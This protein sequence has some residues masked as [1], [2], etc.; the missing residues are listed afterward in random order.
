MC[1][2]PAGNFQNEEDTAVYKKWPPEVES[3]DG[4]WISTKL[5]MWWPRGNPEGLAQ[6]AERSNLYN[7]WE[8]HQLCLHHGYRVKKYIVNTRSATY[9]KTKRGVMDQPDVVRQTRG[10]AC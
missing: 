10:N 5:Y 3:V 2:F 1:P 9:S 4:L 8:R 6:E 7:K